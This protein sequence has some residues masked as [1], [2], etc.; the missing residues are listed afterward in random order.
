MSKAQARETRRRLLKT[1]TGTLHIHIGT[2]LCV[3][4]I[5]ERKGCVWQ[6]ESRNSQHKA[7]KHLSTAAVLLVRAWDWKID[8][9]QANG[10]RPK[11]GNVLAHKMPEGQRRGYEGLCGVYVVASRGKSR[12]LARRG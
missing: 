3:A 12:V 7:S 9:E 6:N 4:R 10:P 8:R 2:V 5:M 1:K 11:D